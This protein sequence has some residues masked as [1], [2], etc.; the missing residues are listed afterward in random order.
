MTGNIRFV[1]SDQRDEEFGSIEHFRVAQ[2]PVAKSKIE[3]WGK[4]QELNGTTVDDLI[5]HRRL[6]IFIEEE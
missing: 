5:V 3:K 2:H 1:E 4:R 6:A